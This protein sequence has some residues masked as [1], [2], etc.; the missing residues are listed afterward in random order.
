MQ[1]RPDANCAHAYM[2]AV[3]NSVYGAAP[4]PLPT[5]FRPTPPNTQIKNTER[6]QV[7]AWFDYLKRELPDVFF[8]QSDTNYP[9]NFAAA[10][11]S[12]TVSDRALTPTSFCRWG[13]RCPTATGN[14]PNSIR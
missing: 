10:E 9:I 2:A 5:C 12:Q 3:A 14:S 8:I 13:T 7:F 4:S 1:N 6:A 11:F